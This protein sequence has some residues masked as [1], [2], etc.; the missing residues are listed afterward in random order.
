MILAKVTPRGLT[1]GLGSWAVIST[2]AT[3]PHPHPPTKTWKKRLVHFSGS[4]VFLLVLQ[5]ASSLP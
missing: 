2:A 4:T 5:G 1:W 3:T